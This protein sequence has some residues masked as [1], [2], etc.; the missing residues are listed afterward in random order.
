MMSYRKY[1]ICVETFTLIRYKLVTVCSNLCNKNMLENLNIK[2]SSEPVS[3]KSSRRISLEQKLQCQRKSSF[4][5]EDSSLSV[6]VFLFSSLLPASPTRQTHTH[7]AFALTPFSPPARGHGSKTGPPVRNLFVI[8]KLLVGVCQNWA[9]PGGSAVKN[10]PAN[11]GDTGSIPG[12]RRSPGGG[13]GNPFQCSCLENSMD[14]GPPGS[15]VPGVVES[16][17]TS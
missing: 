6:W 3:R 7:R 11:E 16:D 8:S 12:L 1:V 4:R 9:S 13:H 2:T 5:P 15:S 10:L 14:C 17:E